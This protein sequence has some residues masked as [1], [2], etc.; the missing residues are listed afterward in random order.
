MRVLYGAWGPTLQEKLRLD[1]VNDGT[2]LHDAIDF[3]LNQRLAAIK[4]RKAIVLLTDGID[5]G[6]KQAGS[7]QN[8]RDAEEAEVIMVYTYHL[9]TFASIMAGFD[10]TVVMFQFQPILK[11]LRRVQNTQ[12]QVT[13][14]AQ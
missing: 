11:L 3:V 10:V 1:A 6:S 12:K 2:L 4:G 8:L 13:Q 7:K 14:R 5:T 9:I